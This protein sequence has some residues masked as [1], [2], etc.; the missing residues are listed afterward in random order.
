MTQPSPRQYLETQVKTASQE[1][2]LI[3]LFD[4]AIRF[5]EQAKLRM[6]A[7]DIEGSHNMLVRSQQIVLEVMTALDRGI[8]EEVYS[9]LM[10][11][12][13]F[14]Y[15]R[16][17]NANVTKDKTQVDEA[18]AVLTHLRDTWR[19]AVD[20]AKRS[21]APVRRAQPRPSSIAGSSFSVQ[22]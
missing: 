5:A 16:L 7:K 22:G 15:R 21:G 4:G 13:N 6:D 12:Y 11:L 17:V 10:G 20:Q 8:G 3:L 1:E 14:I 2:L 19:Q 9:N 18:I